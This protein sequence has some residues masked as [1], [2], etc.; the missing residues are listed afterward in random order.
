MVIDVVDSREM[1]PPL[2]AIDAASGRR[3]SFGSAVYPIAQLL[4]GRI[5]GIVFASELSVHTAG[6]AAI[7]R[8][9]GV[10]VTDV[11]GNEPL[12]DAQSTGTGT[13]VFAWPR[14]HEAILRAVAEASA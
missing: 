12:W 9:L 10:R 13:L 2:H 1:T 14:T 11:A 8:E 7:A 4:L 5:H 3:F 6:G